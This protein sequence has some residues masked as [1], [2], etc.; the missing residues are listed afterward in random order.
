[1]RQGE[2]NRQLK[3][4]KEAFY[5]LGFWGLLKKILG[6]SRRKIFRINRLMIYELDLRKPIKYVSPKIEIN[7]RLATIEDILKMDSD[8]GFD[9]K[10]KDYI[11]NRLKNGDDCVLA[12]FENKIVGYLC[13]M[14][15]KME[16][17]VYKLINISNKRGYVYKGFVW[18]EFRGKR[19][20]N[21]M[22]S[23]IINTLSKRKDITCLLTTVI[24]TNISAITVRERFDWKKAG[25]I[26]QLRILG[27]KYD[28]IGKNQLYALLSKC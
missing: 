21:G 3:S 19:I 5:K 22:D 10:G 14:Y 17:S 2:E 26:L 7:Y 20:I 28:Y 27:F 16:L 18:N 9:K 11:I 1:M 4:L 15:G 6:S 23:Y 12:L 8:H 13:V 25:Y 24:D